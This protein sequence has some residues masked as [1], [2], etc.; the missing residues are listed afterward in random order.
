MKDW[1]GNPIEVG[2]KVVYPVRQGS[3]TDVIEADVVEIV[4]RHDYHLG[5]VP[6]LK[7]RRIREA[8]HLGFSGQEG[9]SWNER[10]WDPA[11]AARDLD[12]RL[13]TLTELSRVTVVG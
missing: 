12:S 5:D 8:R 3:S 4:T 1:R 10:K 13:V 6:A 9:G 7:V 11:P 2:S